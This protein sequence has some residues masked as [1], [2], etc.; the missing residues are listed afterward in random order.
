[1]PLPDAW[2]KLLKEQ[3]PDMY[4]KIKASRQ[5][6]A[7]RTRLAQKELHKGLSDYEILERE[8][9]KVLKKGNTLTREL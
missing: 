5:Q 6:K 1:M 7:E 8:A 2:L 9:Q 4:D 3:N